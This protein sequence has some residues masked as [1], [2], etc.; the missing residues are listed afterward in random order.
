MSSILKS[1]S[2]IFID[3]IPCVSQED[4]SDLLLFTGSEGLTI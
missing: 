3:F 2:Y 4:K 1:N